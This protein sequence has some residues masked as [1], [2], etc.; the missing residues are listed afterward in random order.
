MSTVLPHEFQNQIRAHAR[1]RLLYLLAFVL[2]IPALGA[3]AIV[4]PEYFQEQALPPAPQETV[5]TGD[6]KE[7]TAQLKK[8]QG[9]LT[10]VASTVG[11]RVAL[12]EVIEKIVQNKPA[13]IRLHSFTYIA[14][15]KNTKG[16]LTVTGATNSR[17]DI[18]AFRVALI[19]SELFDSVSLPV[20]VL[21]DSSASSF[22][23]TLT[24]SF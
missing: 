9:L 16:T 4:V 7:A 10:V 18:A 23:L 20:G 8:S 13:G 6:T 11:A 3:A 12:H 17:T 21:V 22:D 19:K 14:P 15:A 2:G 5:V 1:V 24:G